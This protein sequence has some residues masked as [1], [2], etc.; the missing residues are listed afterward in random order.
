MRGRVPF[1]ARRIVTGEIGS[2]EG[3]DRALK[4]RR[5][6]LKSGSD[7]QTAAD[8]ATDSELAFDGSRPR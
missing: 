3:V 5:N 1:L 2:S 6:R 8:S 4:R 7:P